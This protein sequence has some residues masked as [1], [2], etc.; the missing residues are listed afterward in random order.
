MN[1]LL[2]TTVFALCA[3]SLNAASFAAERGT[4]VAYNDDQ[5][6]P[7]VLNETQYTLYADPTFI[8]DAAAVA[9]K[10]APL[11]GSDTGEIESLL[12]ISDT[13]Y[14]ILA[15]RLNHWYKKSVNKMLTLLTLLK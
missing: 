4:I 2:K 15:K 12:K 14:V 9:A 13:R 8:T 3:L 1:K 6:V 5:I 11:V 10:I 7:L